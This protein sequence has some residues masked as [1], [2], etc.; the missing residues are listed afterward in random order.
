MDAKELHTLELFSLLNPKEQCAFI[1]NSNSDFLRFICECI[2]NML[3]GNVPIDPTKLYK[4]QTELS[5]L[6]NKSLSTTVRREIL[7]SRNGIELL[8]IIGKPIL[9]RLK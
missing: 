1:K 3:L 9:K 6:K 2:A 5:H 4:Y 8:N 7:C